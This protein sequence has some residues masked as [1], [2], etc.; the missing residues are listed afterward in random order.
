ML[1]FSPESDTRGSL[2]HDAFIF[3]QQMVK[4]QIGFAFSPFFDLDCLKCMISQQCEDDVKMAPGCF[5]IRLWSEIFYSNNKN[6]L[7]DTMH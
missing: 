4:T 3:Q 2:V 6:K 7:G 5:L 1:V